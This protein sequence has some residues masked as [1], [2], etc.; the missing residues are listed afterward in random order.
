MDFSNF[1]IAPPDRGIENEKIVLLKDY[2]EKG[3]CVGQICKILDIEYNKATWVIKKEELVVKNI[4]QYY[5]HNEDY[6][7]NIDTEE[8]AYILGFIIADGSIEVT[9]RVNEDSKRLVFLNSVDDLE[10]IKLIKE[11][12]SPN[13]KLFFRNNQSGVKVRKE[14]VNLKINSRRICN[15]L[16][17]KYKII[18]NKT[19]DHSFNFDFNLLPKELIRHFIRGYFDGDGSVSFHKNKGSQIFFNFSFVFNSKIFTEQIA[20]IF[21]ELFDIKP[22]IYEHAGKTCNYFL[23]RFDYNRNRTIKI[24]EI[25]EYL[26]EGS[27]CFLVRKKIKF[28]QYFGYR[29]NST[30]KQWRI[31]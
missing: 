29:A 28:E 7:D 8:K 22:V 31:V 30:S 24:G 4:N 11:E 3:Y 10:V 25:Y 9:E 15:T 13:S 18:P 20:N 5:N 14:Q 17:N 1:K 6:F 2:L 26:Y 21:Q 23:L 16:I 12:I 27:K 19:H